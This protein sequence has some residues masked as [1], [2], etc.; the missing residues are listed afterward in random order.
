MFSKSYFIT[1]TH[2]I[3]PY[4]I[5]PIPNYITSQSYTINITHSQ[6]LIFYTIP[7][8]L[9]TLTL[10][11]QSLPSPSITTHIIHNSKNSHHLYSTQTIPYHIPSILL[12]LYQLSTS[13]LF[14]LTLTNIHSYAIHPYLDN[15]LNNPLTLLPP[16]PII[17]LLLFLVPFSRPNMVYPT[18]YHPYATSIK[19]YL[20]RPFYYSVPNYLF[21]LL[22]GDIEI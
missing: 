4:S 8:I 16:L 19:N 10:C 5:L 18:N 9:Y 12:T 6:I 17:L 2:N 14:A 15:H 7:H 11:L 13:L 3:H 20:S 21:L 1:K 22:G